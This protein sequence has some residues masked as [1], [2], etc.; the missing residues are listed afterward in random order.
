MEDKQGGMRRA[1]QESKKTK[2]MSR[3][4]EKEETDVV[5]DEYREI[6]EK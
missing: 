4:Q 3:R 6:G 5:K 1:E 2:K